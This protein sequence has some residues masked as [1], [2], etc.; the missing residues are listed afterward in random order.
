[1]TTICRNAVDKFLVND[2]HKPK[3]DSVFEASPLA[4]LTFLWRC[5]WFKILYHHLLKLRRTVYL[6]WISQ[7]A[8]F[9]YI[10]SYISYKTGSYQTMCKSTFGRLHVVKV[11]NEHKLSLQYL[12]KFLF[13]YYAQQDPV[14]FIS[15]FNSRNRKTM[16]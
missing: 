16:F 5:M 14:E 3:I 15:I 12:T 13:S 10:R 11:Q 1:M 8:N 9:K 7:I 2:V 4:L 6:C